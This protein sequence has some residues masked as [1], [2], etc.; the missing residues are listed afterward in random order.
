MNLFV[1]GFDNP[2]NERLATVF[3]YPLSQVRTGRPTDPSA[4]ATLLVDLLH[5]PTI[6]FGK[7]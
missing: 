2:C 4:Q 5:T 1:N 6:F 3:I 7:Y